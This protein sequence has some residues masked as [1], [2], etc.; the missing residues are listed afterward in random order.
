MRAI[1]AVRPGGDDLQ[2]HPRKPGPCIKREPC[3][4]CEGGEVRPLHGL[5]RDPARDRARPAS[6][7]PCGICVVARRTDRSLPRRGIAGAGDLSDYRQDHLVAPGGQPRPVEQYD[8][9]LLEGRT[10]AMRHN[11][12]SSNGTT[13]AAWFCCSDSWRHGAEHYPCTSSRSVPVGG[14]PAGNLLSFEVDSERQAAWSAVVRERARQRSAAT[15][16]PGGRNC[17]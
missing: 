3:P 11:G 14:L 5:L 12:K 1:F 16:A 7:T 8:I 6:S 2:A 10:T 13:P 9:V 15:A 4:T 17:D